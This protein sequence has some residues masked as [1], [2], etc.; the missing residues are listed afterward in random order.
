MI[1]FHSPQPRGATLIEVAVVILVIVLAMVL[2]LPRLLRARMGA[3]EAA[4]ART[5]RNLV[6]H[7]KNFKAEAI[8]DQD[9]DGVGEYGLL[10]ELA[11]DI[12]PRAASRR[13]HLA[14]AVL[15]TGGSAEG[16]DG[17]AVTN[18]YVYRIV[19]AG[20]MLED[21][22]AIA[23]DDLTL[24]GSARK[25]GATLSDVDAID[26]QEQRFAIYAWPLRA[27]DTGNRA[28]VATQAG[29]LLSTSMDAR[30]YSGRGPMGSESTPAPDAAYAGGLFA[31]EPV[32]EQPG[33]DGNLWKSCAAGAG[34]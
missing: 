25:P 22:R 4:A 24:G 20:E 19:L 27:G 5:L 3:N 29:H 12:V 28:F 11:G 33:S 9:A 23:G 8:V 10:G 14:T 17:C 21:S 32:G 13:F 18:G 30:T 15:S 1:S 7:Q 2:V 26:M 6:A 34:P 31:G 16:G